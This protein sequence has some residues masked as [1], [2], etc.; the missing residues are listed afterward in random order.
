MRFTTGRS[1]AAE[2]PVSCSY[3][4]NLHGCRSRAG[5]HRLSRRSSRPSRQPSGAG[6]SVHAQQEA[7]RETKRQAKAERP[8]EIAGRPVADST[9]YEMPV[10]WHLCILLETLIQALSF[11]L[12]RM[13]LVSASMLIAANGLRAN[14]T[15][16]IHSSGH[17]SPLWRLWYVLITEPLYF[18]YPGPCR[19]NVLCRPH[20]SVEAVTAAIAAESC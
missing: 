12:P 18:S 4:S 1:T 8:P 3:S 6:F 9:P 2:S 15:E 10:V 14:A 16:S 5:V 7:A 20:K 19:R 13:L 11:R 17:R